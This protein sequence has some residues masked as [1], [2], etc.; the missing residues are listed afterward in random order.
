MLISLK[1][2]ISDRLPKISY[3]TLL[4]IYLHSSYLIMM[5]LII[6]TCAFAYVHSPVWG[7]AE[8]GEVGVGVPVEG[9]EGVAVH[10]LG[11]TLTVQEPYLLATFSSAWILI[12]VGLV[13]IYYSRSWN[14]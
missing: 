12:H 8:V 13:A 5:G 1:F 14:V 10:V 4:D 3:L 9:T 7:P 2:I 11:R 6:Y